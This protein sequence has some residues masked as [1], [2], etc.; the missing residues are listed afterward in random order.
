MKPLILIQGP[1][2]TRSGYGDHARSIFY[3]LHDSGKYNIKL[4]DVRWGDTPRN[5]LKQDNPHLFYQLKIRMLPFE[6]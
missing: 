6:N 5:F 2:A 4:W 1:I 3:A